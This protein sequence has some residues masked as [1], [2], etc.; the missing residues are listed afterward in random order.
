MTDQIQEINNQQKSG[1]KIGLALGGG[2]AKGLAHIGVIKALERAQIPIDYIAG[3]SMGALVGGWYAMTKNIWLLESLFLQIKDNDIFLGKK[4]LKNKSGVLFRDEMIIEF[5][6]K[7]FKNKFVENFCGNCRYA[8]SSQPRAF[9]PL[10]PFSKSRYA[11]Y[12]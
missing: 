7:G 9:W 12:F 5:L 8:P 3:T 2:G 4:P 1:K 6:E 11:F 10:N